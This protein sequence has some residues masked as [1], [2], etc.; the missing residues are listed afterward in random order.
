MRLYSL[1]PLSFFKFGKEK[2]SVRISFLSEFG[3]LNLRIRGPQLSDLS[4][5]SW[6]GGTGQRPQLRTAS[7]LVPVWFFD[8]CF[9][10]KM[11]IIMEWKWEHRHKYVTIISWGLR[12]SRASNNALYSTGSSHSL[13]VCPYRLCYHHKIRDLRTSNWLGTLDAL[14]YPIEAPLP[15]EELLKYL[16]VLSDKGEGVQRGRKGLSFTLPPFLYSPLLKVAFL[17]KVYYICSRG[18][19]LYLSFQGHITSSLCYLSKNWDWKEYTNGVMDRRAKYFFSEILAKLVSWLLVPANLNSFCHARM[20]MR[21]PAWDLQQRAITSVLSP[22]LQVL[23]GSKSSLLLIFVLGWFL[24]L[25][26]LSPE[27]YIIRIHCVA[28]IIRILFYSFKQ[29]FIRDQNEAISIRTPRTAEAS[30][31]QKCQ[32]R[33]SPHTIHIW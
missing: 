3:K 1:L 29:N 6:P 25:E 11:E 21:L 4:R 12:N 20:S 9:L 18:R 15:N 22:E 32:W 10:L 28:A 16:V 26:F 24:D 13:T 7:N 27:R 14:P 8:D 33:S 19:G 17:L 30:I 5:S 2:R 31:Y 23:T